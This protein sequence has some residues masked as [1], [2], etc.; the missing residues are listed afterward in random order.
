M[1]E[2]GLGPR[3]LS[4]PILRMDSWRPIGVGVIAKGGVACGGA[5][6]CVGCGM[7]M[8]TGGDHILDNDKLM[9]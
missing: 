2:I 8:G 9:G 6:Q 3:C 5:C 7:R 1:F 4:W